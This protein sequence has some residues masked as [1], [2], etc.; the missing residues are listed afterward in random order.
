MQHL[1]SWTSF[2]LSQEYALVQLGY[3]S[4]FNKHAPGGKKKHYICAF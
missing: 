4:S 2:R 1:V 3:L